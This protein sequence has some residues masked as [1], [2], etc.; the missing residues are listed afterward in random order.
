MKAQKQYQEL[1]Y[2]TSSKKILEIIILQMVQELK[3][4]PGI[5]IPLLI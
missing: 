4:N 5:T 1:M 3:K 2:P